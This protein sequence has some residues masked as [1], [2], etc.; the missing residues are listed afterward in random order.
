MYF[1]FL[2]EPGFLPRCTAAIF[3]KH[4]LKRDTKVQRAVAK[5]AISLY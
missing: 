3:C 4:I 2:K 5:K 1:W